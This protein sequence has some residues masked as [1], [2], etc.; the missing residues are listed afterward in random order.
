MIPVQ[1]SPEE[2]V[3]LTN[4]LDTVTLAGVQEK[5]HAA[6]VQQKIA[7]G[8]QSLQQEGVSDEEPAPSQD[9]GGSGADGELVRPG[10]ADAAD[11]S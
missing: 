2:A 9:A 10:S 6:N 11:R 8:V 5:V 7:L 1:L 4:K 3:F